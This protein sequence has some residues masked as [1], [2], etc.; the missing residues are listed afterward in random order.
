[1]R[2]SLAT[3]CA[4][5]VLAA[6]VVLA[7]HAH[8]ARAQG[9]QTKQGVPGGPPPGQGER[10]PGEGPGGP[11]P[12]YEWNPARADS[13]VMMMLDHIKG[14]EDMPA[15]SVYKN[16]KIL[17]GMPAKRLPGI[18]VRG[19]SRSLGMRCGGCHVRDD[20]AS[21]DRPNKRIAREM[22]AM[23]QGINK[24]TLPSIKDIEV[25]MPMVNCW[26]CHRGQHEP[27]T[28]PDAPKKPADAQAAPGQGAPGQGAPKPEPSH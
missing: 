20:F 17:K 14:K 18:M 5:A 23:V 16:I 10:K 15:E 19:F 25:E 11:Q 27:E 8:V 6:A 22:W 21:D 4:I 28:N 26:T 9:S 24:N 7:L 12:P 13:T 3:L 1:M 2:R